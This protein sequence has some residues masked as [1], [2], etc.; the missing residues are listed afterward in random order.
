L[1]RDDNATP[2]LTVYLYISGVALEELGLLRLYFRILSY[3][4][5]F[6]RDNNFEDAALLKRLISHAENHPKNH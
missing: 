4:Y 6:N 5:A 3:I 2:F 1:N